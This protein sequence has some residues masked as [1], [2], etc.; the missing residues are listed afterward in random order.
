MA[1]GE[2]CLIVFIAFSRGI[3]PLP[4]LAQQ[5]NRLGNTYYDL[6]PF[7]LSDLWSSIG[8]IHSET[9]GQGNALRLFRG[10]LP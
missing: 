2:K 3:W 9:K 1:V 7:P 4:D 5:D 6:S 10:H 8:Q